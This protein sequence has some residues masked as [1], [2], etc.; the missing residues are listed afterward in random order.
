[1]GQRPKV[2]LSS[3]STMLAPAPANGAVAYPPLRGHADLVTP[4]D[5]EAVVEATS[6]PIDVM[7]E[8]KAKDLALLNLRAN[9]APVRPHIAALEERH[10]SAS[11]MPSERRLRA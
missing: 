10:S 11:R 9:L 8:A 7:L 1:V 4:W 3:A 5:L 2:H 6:S